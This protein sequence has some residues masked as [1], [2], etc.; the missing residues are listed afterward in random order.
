MLIRYPA[1]ATLTE[2]D[3]FGHLEMRLSRE[4]A[5]MRDPD[6]RG[7]W[8]DGFIPEKF[9][10]TGKGCHVSGKVWIDSGGPQAL[11]NFVVLL[12]LRPKVATM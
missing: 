6:L 8:C 4:F 7:W 1:E 5:G 10:A 2:T 3:Y 12:A 9:V 11:W